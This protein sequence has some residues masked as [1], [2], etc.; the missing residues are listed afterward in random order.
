MIDRLIDVVDSL[1]IG[2]GTVLDSSPMYGYAEAVLGELVPKAF[3][4]LFP[5]DVSR[6]VA[7]PLIGFAWLMT[8]P[9]AVLNGS[10]THNAAQR[11]QPVRM[12][13][14]TS[15]GKPSR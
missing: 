1:L 3:A 15:P 10:V 11:R 4:L 2:G 7:A 5:E 9:I 13:T 12:S 14:S 6:W 8:G